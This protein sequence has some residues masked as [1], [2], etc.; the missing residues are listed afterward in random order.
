MPKVIKVI[1]SEIK[2]G[3]GINKGSIKYPNGIKQHT[4]LHDDLVRLV[5]QYHTLDGKF[6]AEVDSRTEEIM[7]DFNLKEENNK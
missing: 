7:S 2:M 6:L 3:A 4:V 5:I 1:V